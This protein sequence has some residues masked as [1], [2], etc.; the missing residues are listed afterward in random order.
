V[1]LKKEIIEIKKISNIALNVSKFVHLN[2]TAIKK[3]LKKYDKN[4]QHIFGSITFPYIQKKLD[5]K[6]SDLFYILNLKIIDEVSAIV[7]DLMLEL[8]KLVN[9]KSGGFTR[10]LTNHKNSG[11]KILS[12][13]DFEKQDL[14]DKLIFANSSSSIV[15]Q[16]PKAEFEDMQNVFSILESNIYQLDELNLNFRNAFKEWTFHLKNINKGYN[17][18]YSIVAKA[19]IMGL[20]VASEYPD[21]K[22]AVS[23]TVFRY[24]GATATTDLFFNRK[25]TI[26]SEIL[27][28][29]ENLNN[30]YITL[31]HSFMFMLAYSI[32][33]PTNCLFM[34]RIQ[35]EKYS[36]G[37]ALGMTPIGT[38]FSLFIDR[39]MTDFS[40]KKPLLLSAFFF[41]ISSILYILA[42]TTKSYTLVLLSR[43][44]LGVGSFRLLNRTYLTLFVGQRKISKYLLYFQLCSLVGLASGPLFS[45][46]LSII[47]ESEAFMDE[48]LNNIFNSCTLPAWFLL[49]F[50]CLLMFLITVYYSEPLN[51]NF[52]SFRDGIDSE[53]RSI[54]IDRDR[55]SMRDKTMIDQIDDKL[56]QINDNNNFSDTNLVSRHI[57]QIASKESKMNSYL[58]KCFIVF[59]ILLIIIR[60]IF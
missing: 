10:R 25:N 11:E 55:M 14:S 27:F 29:K 4:F 58:Y 32:V 28:T 37:L 31:V 46:P 57:Q 30:I 20:P 9:N 24:G 44:I 17:N 40:Y 60:V 21:H 50:S 42:G 41:I 34:H 51:L 19:S 52:M 1:N 13:S 54:N 49:V 33:I 53:T 47:G 15:N 26:N 56:S 45:I 16:I 43:F 48:R 5:L 6:H 59:I 2:M 12:N 7:E 35:Y 23:G 18:G 36:S 8:K 38:I 3:I 39:K 22:S